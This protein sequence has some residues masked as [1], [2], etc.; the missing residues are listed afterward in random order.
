MCF[1]LT[2]DSKG[3][4]RLLCDWWLKISV[5]TD[6]RSLRLPF[7]HPHPLYWE[8]ECRSGGG[9]KLSCYI[10]TT[11]NIMCTLIKIHVC[12][13]PPTLVDQWGIGNL[14]SQRSHVGVSVDSWRTQGRGEGKEEEEEEDA[15]GNR[16]P[17]C[18]VMV[19][20]ISG[21]LGCWISA[22]LH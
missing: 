16:R 19:L 1:I 15:L 13:L 6:P 22:V 3:G 4:Q 14:F 21:D 9:K 7:C 12:S 11:P 18:L 20:V 10:I 2:R 5:H 8:E 17:S